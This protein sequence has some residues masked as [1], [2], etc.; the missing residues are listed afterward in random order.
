MQPLFPSSAGRPL[1]ERERDFVLEFQIGSEWSN[2]EDYFRVTGLQPGKMMPT[3]ETWSF[4]LQQI[5]GLTMT[6]GKNNR[7]RMK[8]KSWTISRFTRCLWYIHWQLCGTYYW[9]KQCGAGERRYLLPLSRTKVQFHVK[10]Q[11]DGRVGE[12][13][14]GNKNFTDCGRVEAFLTQHF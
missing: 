12:M 6:P 11:C 14:I 1:R 4:V 7:W 2:F 9:A 8:T 3:I 10:R 5:K 13:E